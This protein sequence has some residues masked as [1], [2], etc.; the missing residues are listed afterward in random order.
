[1]KSKIKGKERGNR[2]HFKTG[3]NLSLNTDFVPS[4]MSKGKKRLRWTFKDT[5]LR[6][7]HG[8]KQP[9]F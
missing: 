7:T 4:P 1:M 3:A 5:L 6:F 8:R 9:R 2:L